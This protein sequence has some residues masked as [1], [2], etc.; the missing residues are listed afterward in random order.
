MILKLNI[1]HA[2]ELHD[3]YT[4]TA[5]EVNVVLNATSGVWY[6]YK[7][8][9]FNEKWNSLLKCR[10]DCKVLRLVFRIIGIFIIKVIKNWV[11]HY[12]GSKNLLRAPRLWTEPNLPLR[13]HTV[14]LRRH[15]YRR[16][17]HLLRL[18]QFHFN[19]TGWPNHK[20]CI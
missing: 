1:T 3:L 9:N 12:V 8:P 11:K 6:E 19:V 20:I 14:R 7:S 5:V 4:A 17:D 2:E 18:C 15:H 13:L 10:K 16:R